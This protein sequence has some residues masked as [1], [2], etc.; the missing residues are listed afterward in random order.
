MITSVD[1]SPS[2]LTPFYMQRFKINDNINDIII[3]KID[4]WGFE[5]FFYFEEK[6]IKTSFEKLP[7]D[8]NVPFFFTN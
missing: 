6:F 8:A 1:L 5:F 2:N 7:P 4:F 3:P